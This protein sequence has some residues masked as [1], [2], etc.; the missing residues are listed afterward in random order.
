MAKNNIDVY[1]INTCKNGYFVTL[2]FNNLLIKFTRRKSDEKA[3]LWLN[4]IENVAKV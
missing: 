1:T 4:Y 2:D 3:R